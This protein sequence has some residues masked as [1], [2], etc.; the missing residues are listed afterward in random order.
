[1][2]LRKTPLW[3]RDVYI[4]HFENGD[5]SIVSV[6]KVT[7][8]HNGICSVSY[9]SSITAETI[10]SLHK[11]DDKEVRE[12]VKAIT[13]EDNIMRNGRLANKKKWDIEHPDKPNPYDKPPKVIRLESIISNA[14]LDEIDNF[15]YQ[16]LDEDNDLFELERIESQRKQVK[17]FVKTFNASMQELYDL[18]Y[19]QGLNQNQVGKKLNL[20]RSTISTR[21]KWLD[22]KIFEKFSK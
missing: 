12:N 6:G 2:K 3:Q 11:A 18:L 1:M 4:Y 16:N 17:D 10:K 20:T 9:D 5:K 14:T 19:I 21:K 8:Y 13:F 22:R 7:D 15:L